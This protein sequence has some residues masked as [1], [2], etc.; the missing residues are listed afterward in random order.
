LGW[1]GR[2]EGRKKEKGFQFSKSTQANEF[3]T[4][5]ESKHPKTMHQHECNSKLLYFFNELKND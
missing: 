2:R 4:R 3:K 5:F 1:K